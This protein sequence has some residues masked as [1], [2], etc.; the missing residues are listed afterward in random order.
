MAQPQQQGFT[1]LAV[2]ATLLIVALGTQGVMTYVSQQA[3]RE[4]ESDLLRIGQAYAEAIGTY[5]EA[6]PGRIKQWPRNLDDLLEDRRVVTIKRHIRELYP[7]PIT[8]SSDWGLV[9]AADGGISGVY[10]RSAAVPLRTA[11]VEAGALIL[12]PASRYADWQFVYTPAPVTPTAPASQAA[13][14]AAR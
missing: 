13:P 7:D 11:A 8:R 14:Q 6:T 2:L 4:R 9:K 10:S 3:Q 5:Y 1:Y 12:A